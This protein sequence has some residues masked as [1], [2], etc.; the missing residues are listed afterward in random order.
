[1]TGLV[2]SLILPWALG[3]VWVYWLL[4]QSV[5]WNGFVVAG[6]GYLLGIFLTTLLI[7][8]WSATGLPLHYWS[9]AA[10][11]FAMT[12]VGL[13]AIRLQAVPA[14]KT[15]VSSRP[16][17]WELVVTALFLA[18]ILYRYATIFQEILLRPLFPWDVWMNWA[19]KA[20]VWYHYSELLH[21]VSVPEWLQ[22]PAEALAYTAGA[23]DA[24]KY[25][26]TIP[27]IQL[28]GMMAM[29][30]SDHTLI[31]LPWFFAA[32]AL[33][34]TLY[35]HLRLSGV[36]VVMSTLACYLLMNLP[37]INV[38]VALAGY[39]DIWLAAAFGCAVFAL[40]AWDESRQWRYGLL[41]L[42]LAL[43]CSQLKIPGVILGGIVCA[44]FLS[45]L[46]NPT[47][48]AWWILAAIL[49]A[50]FI[51]LAF[52]GLDLSIPGLGRLAISMD[53]I[54]LPYIGYY[55]IAFHPVQHA[56]V[57]TFL[58]MINWNLLWY[59]FIFLGVVMVTKGGALTA[60]S[61]VLRSLLLALFFIL[62]VYFFTNR[63]QFALD[64][65]QVN[66]A[67][68]FTTPVLV[69]YLVLASCALRTTS[70]TGRLT[71][72]SRGSH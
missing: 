43:M 22:S 59:L 61:L 6:Y 14:A 51:Y 32:I 62:F 13:V 56:M 17:K 26:E 66:R 52:V 46:V 48:R 71:R 15:Q 60:P 49:S 57:N 35:G 33:G 47:R 10:T 27:L 42:L 41:A 44:V 25:P 4:R 45:S 18:L 24:W 21:W 67:L 36:S 69:F 72:L 65:T 34:F 23:G 53:G 31:Y 8:A 50:C 28:W 70:P 12:L 55:E 1:M 64:Y 16:E 2:T 19:P 58:V 5:H 7:R 40:H 63:Y 3:G 11:L 29:G 37:F 54:V 20:I 30:T 9:M 68:I 39:A 38:H